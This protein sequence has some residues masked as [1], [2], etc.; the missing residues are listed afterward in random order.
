MDEGRVGQ[1]VG[2]ERGRDADASSGPPTGL[3]SRWRCRQGSHTESVSAGLESITVPPA[4][5]LIA[6]VARRCGLLVC[7]NDQDFERIPGLRRYQP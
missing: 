6:A 4:D 2:R 7:A 3:S 1:G 5:C